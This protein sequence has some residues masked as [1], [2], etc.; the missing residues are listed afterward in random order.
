MRRLAS[1]AASGW[2][3]LGLVLLGIVILATA[4]GILARLAGS[5]GFSWSFEVLAFA[6]LWLSVIG[7]ILAEVRGENVAFDLIDTRLPSRAA[8][9]L[10]IGRHLVLALFGLAIARSGW[11]MLG[12]TAFAPSPVLRMPMWIPQSSVLLLGLGLACAQGYL[13]LRR[14]GKAK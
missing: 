1:L 5:N 10:A 13:I 9:R 11:A 8:L 3:L 2:K 7:V 12:R 14:L 6:F 4:A